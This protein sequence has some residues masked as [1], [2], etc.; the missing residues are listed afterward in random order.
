MNKSSKK[1]KSLAKPASKR[2]IAIKDLKAK[3]AGS[4]KGGEST[5]KDHKDRLSTGILTRR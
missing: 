4:L 5:D 2:K 3:D 1:P